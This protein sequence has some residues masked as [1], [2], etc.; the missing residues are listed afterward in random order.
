MEQLRKDINYILYDIVKPKPYIPRPL[1]ITESITD[2]YMYNSADVFVEN[3]CY[4]FHYILSGVG[5]VVFNGKV[6]QAGP[7]QCFLCHSKSDDIHYR[8]PKEAKE[9]WHFISFTFMQDNFTAT[10]RNIVSSTPVFSIPKN[11]QILNIL[12]NNLTAKNR[13][14]LSCA[15]GANIVYELIITLLRYSNDGEQK[16]FHPIINKVESIIES[17]IS[18]N[19]SVTE[20]ADELAISRE[21][22][23]RIFKENTGETLK[24][25]IQ[26]EMFL[27]LDMMLTKKNN[28]FITIIILLVRLDL[29]VI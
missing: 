10:Y 27:V 11:A 5:E 8:F 18:K 21:Y 23:S 3:E 20:I 25:Y 15:E 16:E 13:I 9:P 19:I 6:Y 7:G 22:L 24:S 26:K 17:R 28:Q 14:I 12:N 4:D 2:T 29:L 1:R